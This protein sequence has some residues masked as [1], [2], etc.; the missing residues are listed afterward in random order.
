MKKEILNV[1]RSEE[2]LKI[3]RP[4]VKEYSQEKL[5]YKN[6]ESDTNE[7][8]KWKDDDSHIASKP[9]NHIVSNEVKT[10]Q[11]SNEKM[12]R[13]SDIK[14]NRSSEK[15]SIIESSPNTPSNSASNY[16]KSSRTSYS[17]RNGSGSAYLSPYAETDISPQLPITRVFQTHVR[18]PIIEVNSREIVGEKLEEEDEEE[19]ELSFDEYIPITSKP[20]PP[21]QVFPPTALSLSLSTPKLTAS[22]H[23]SA[24]PGSG[25]SNRTYRQPSPQLPTPRVSASSSNITGSSSSSSSEK[26]KVPVEIQRMKNHDFLL[27]MNNP[28]SKFSEEKRYRTSDITDPNTLKYLKK[29]VYSDEDNSLSAKKKKYVL[30]AS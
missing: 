24:F 18:Q 1:H 14:I 29:N 20:S 11:L 5:T 28:L 12:N 27:T 4:I 30:D 13:S 25:S 22:Y 9:T 2:P 16:Y 21:P 23:S 26:S 15:I 8:R 17:P 7:K 19:E 3:T 6:G 10:N